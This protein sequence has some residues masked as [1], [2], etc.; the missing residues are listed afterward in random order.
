MASGSHLVDAVLGYKETRFRRV[1]KRYWE[2]VGLNIYLLK[3]MK[4]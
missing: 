4:Y 1:R 3:H 2:P